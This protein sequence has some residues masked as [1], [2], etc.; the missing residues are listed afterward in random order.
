MDSQEP[1]ALQHRSS[2]A[3]GWLVKFEATITFGRAH[4]VAAFEFHGP[5]TAPESRNDSFPPGAVLSHQAALLFPFK[6]TDF[7]VTC[8]VLPS[9]VCLRP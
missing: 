2:E 3:H 1:Y 4:A 6:G 7:L 8:D 5:V 9:S